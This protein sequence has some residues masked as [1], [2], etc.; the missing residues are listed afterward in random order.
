MT[1]IDLLATA[2]APWAHLYNDSRLLS[3]MMGFCHVG[4][5]MY[6]GGRAVTA[7]CKLL[8]L[9]RH[10]S[11]F[12]SRPRAEVLEEIESAHRPV[13]LGLGVT[14]VSG[15]LMWAADIRSLTGSPVFWIKMG[16]VVLLLANGYFL[17]RARTGIARGPVT[18]ERAW[19]GLK[20]RAR[21]SLALWFGSVLLG[22]A[23]LSA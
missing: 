15:A 21:T 6:G 13:L 5:L 16:V 19:N 20:R 10:G 7:D 11:R 12:H 14:L 9:D 22:T 23:L 4:G 1:V 2:A 18:P 3:V 17:A 8:E